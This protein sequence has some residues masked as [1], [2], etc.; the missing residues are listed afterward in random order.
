MHLHPFAVGVAEWSDGELAGIVEGIELDLLARRAEGLPEVALLPE[1]TDADQ[2]HA[3]VAGRL[4]E[5]AG[6]DAQAAAVDGEGLA[7]AEL[8]AEVRDGPKGGFRVSLLKPG[9]AS[10]ASR[11][12]ET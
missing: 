1:Q 8:H 2:R 6:Q 4:E 3:Q 5:V 7:Q 10:S 11:L 9:R 12:A